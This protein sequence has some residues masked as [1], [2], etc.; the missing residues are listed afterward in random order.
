MGAVNDCESGHPVTADDRDFGL[1]R[2]TTA[3]RH[4]RCDLF[5]EGLATVVRQRPENATRGNTPVACAQPDC[6]SSWLRGD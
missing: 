5:V 4:H 1:S 6:P 2:F 3:H